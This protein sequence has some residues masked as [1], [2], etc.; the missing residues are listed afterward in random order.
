M[1]NV[2]QPCVLAFSHVPLIPNGFLLL[3]QEPDPLLHSLALFAKQIFL[4]I[5]DLFIA[6]IY[7][8]LQP[9]SQFLDGRSQLHSESPVRLHFLGLDFQQPLVP[10]IFSNPKPVC[11]DEC[12]QAMRH[13]HNLAQDLRTHCQAVIDMTLNMGF[14]ICQLLL[15]E[16]N[17]CI[18]FSNDAVQAVKLSLNPALFLLCR[19]LFK[20]HSEIVAPRAKTFLFPPQVDFM[21]FEMKKSAQ[22]VS[23]V[24]DGFPQLGVGLNQSALQIS[25]CATLL[26]QQSEEGFGQL[27]PPRS[28]SS[29]PRKLLLTESQIIHKRHQM[30]SIQRHFVEIVSQV[31]ETSL[32]IG[33]ELGQQLFHHFFRDFTHRR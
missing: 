8:R 7:S 2:L 33:V 10:Q 16:S 19:A 1:D 14:P 13:R 5:R 12:Q 21:L 22:S 4:K 31:V 28:K 29:F 26:L 9:P 6:K 11:P 24:H 25:R 23:P 3:P 27:L 20:H 15:K 18:S 32:P 30:I 17:S